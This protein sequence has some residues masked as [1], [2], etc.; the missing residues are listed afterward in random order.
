MTDPL[1]VWLLVVMLCGYHYSRT[2]A[3]W[4]LV[5]ILCDYQGGRYLAAWLVVVRPPCDCCSSQWLS[6]VAA[7][8]VDIIYLVAEYRVV[9]D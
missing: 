9:S 1:G 2:L 7:V 5:V 4:L 6:C 8:A 3:V